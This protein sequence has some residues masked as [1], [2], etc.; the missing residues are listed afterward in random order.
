MRIVAEA[1]ALAC[2]LSLSSCILGPIAAS[3]LSSDQMQALKE[4]NQDGDVYI[5]GIVGGPPPAGAIT[6]L[7]LPKGTDAKITFNSDCHLK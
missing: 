6:F 4:Y 7:V 2:L 3:N 1:F 5:C